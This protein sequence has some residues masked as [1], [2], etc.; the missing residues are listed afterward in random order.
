[1]AEVKIHC[2]FDTVLKIRMMLKKK[3]YKYGVLSG[4]ELPDGIDFSIKHQ[5]GARESMEHTLVFKEGRIKEKSL[6]KFLL[7]YLI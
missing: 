7:E 6:K 1:M 2:S 5:S 4:G 3:G